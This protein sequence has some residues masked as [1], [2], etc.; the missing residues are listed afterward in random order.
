MFIVFCAVDILILSR[1]SVLPN[2]QAMDFHLAL[3]FV[4]KSDIM[5]FD[6]EGEYRGKKKI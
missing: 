4:K 2:V 5:A 3:A 6:K 1:H